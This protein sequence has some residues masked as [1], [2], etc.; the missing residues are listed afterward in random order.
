VSLDLAGPERMSFVDATAMFR[1]WLRWPDA[2]RV[3]IPR[4]LS[5]LLYK[6][7]DVVRALGW[8]TPISSTARLEMMRGA[9]GDPSQWFEITG[10]RGHSVRHKLAGEPASVQERWFA[11][12]YILKPFVFGIF[13]LFWLV[14]GTISL[15]P[16]WEDGLALMHEGGVTG[17]MA[18]AAVIAG[19]CADLA[20][21]AAIL[22]RR[23]ARWGL[24]AALFITMTYVILG[25][26]IAP[27][28]WREPLGPMVKVF[29][30]MVLNLVAMAIREDR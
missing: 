22:W 16:G 21:G 14:T 23:T 13:G 15:G 6:T 5:A 3:K 17:T 19:A 1:A 18:A 2:R 28:L 26:F 27:R 25:S 11:R 9:T 12:L 10:I 4:S 8:P 7:G 29:P 30:I 20:I 24:W